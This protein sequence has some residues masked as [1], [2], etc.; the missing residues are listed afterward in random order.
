VSHCVHALVCVGR[1]VAFR[2]SSCRQAGLSAGLS[3]ASNTVQIEGQQSLP[4]AAI[5]FRDAGGEGGPL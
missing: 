1:E 5:G 2:T 4:A 3:E